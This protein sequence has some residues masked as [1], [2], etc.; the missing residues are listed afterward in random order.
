MSVP[1]NYREIEKRWQAKWDDDSLY[2]VDLDALAAS[3]GRTFTNLAEFPYPSAEGLHVGHVFKWCGLDVIGRW[4]RMQGEAVFQPIGFDS[5]GINAENYAMTRR[6]HPAAVIERTSK[7]FRRQLSSVGI[8]WDWSR[9]FA[10]SDPSYYR[11]TQWIFVKLLRAGLAYQAE[12]PVTWCPGCLTVLAREQTE[13]NRCERCE[14]PVTERVLKQWFLSTTTHATRLVAG[15]EEL[16]WPASAKAKQRNWV[17]LEPDGSMRL[18]DWLVSRQR[19]WGA[20][21]PVVHC[22]DCG[23][24]AVPEDELPVLLPQVED[25]NLIVPDGSG[26]SPLARFRE[27]VEVSCPGCGEPASRDTD[28]LDTFVDSSWYFLRYGSTDSDDAPWSAERVATTL[29]VG[30]YAGGPEHVTRHHL[31][32]RF[33]TVALHD[34]GLVDFEEPFPHMRVGGFIRLGGVKMNKSKGNVVTPDEL[35]ATHGGDVVRVALLFSGRW[36]VD[37]DY[38]SN[39]FVGAERF[40]TRVWKLVDRP[41]ANRADPDESARAILRVSEQIEG[42]AFNVAVARLME[43]VGAL[44][45]HGADHVAKR[46]LVLLLAPFAPYLAEELWARLGGAYSVHTQPWPTVD[47]ETRRRLASADIEVAVQI[48][49]QLRTRVRMPGDVTADDMESAVMESPDVAA[50]LGDRRVT[51]VITVPNR[52]VNLITDATT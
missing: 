52:L 26:Q 48:D 5:F 29:P 40:L 41:T 51:R 3:G 42:L 34:L 8:A 32:A 37:H 14:T 19:F 22:D 1:Y 39:G 28:V 35:V 17:G 21:I 7:T 20:P 36:D 4:R 15:L 10:T 33:M 24:V 18:H 23:A 44:E 27:W 2:E 45:R 49:G 16:D 25:P 9:V 30:F 11:W 13:D 46:T 12:A 43:F 31:Y 6:E 50:A 47:A 38:E